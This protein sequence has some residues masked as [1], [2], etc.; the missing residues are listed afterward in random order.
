[1]SQLAVSPSLLAVTLPFDYLAFSS[2]SL[3]RVCHKGRC[4]AL[5]R[6]LILRT[7]T[8]PLP[9]VSLPVVLSASAAGMVAVAT[10][11]VVLFL[12]LLCPKGVVVC[13]RLAPRL[14]SRRRGTRGLR[15]LRSVVTALVALAGTISPLPLLVLPLLPLLTPP[16]QIVPA[17]GQHCSSGPTSVQSGSLRVVGFGPMRGGRLSYIYMQRSPCLARGSF[18]YIFVSL[19][20]ILFLD[21]PLTFCSIKHII[22]FVLFFYC[23]LS[24]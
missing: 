4:Y 3:P 23:C 5:R 17:T 15:S 20:F 14:V 16:P 12:S 6:S 11:S 9:V 1:M 8:R 19:G 13:H 7:E 10:P 22:H 24:N 2:Q 21:F 18:S